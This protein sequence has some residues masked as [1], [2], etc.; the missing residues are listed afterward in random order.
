MNR[1]S[2]RATGCIRRCIQALALAATVSGCATTAADHPQDPFEGFNRAMFSFNDRLDQA[3]LKPAATVYA[4]VLPSFM[5]TA[6]GNF[7]GNIGDVWTAVN[8]LLQGKVENGLSD[9]M[10][11]AVN[12]T[13]GLVGL[14]DFGS[15]LGMPK[16]KEDFGQ[17]LGAWGM[18]S[19]PYVVLPFLGSTTL[20]DTAALPVDFRGDLWTYERPVRLRNAGSAVRVVDQRAAVL[21]ASNLIEDAA[22]DRYEFVRDAYLQRRANK[23]NDGNDPAP[24]REDK[25]NN[26]DSPT[27]KRDD[28][29]SRNQVPDE[30]GG[31]TAPE[32]LSELKLQSEVQLSGLGVEGAIDS[33]NAPGLSLPRLQKIVMSSYDIW[34]FEAAMSSG[35]RRGLMKEEQH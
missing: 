34:A 12:T 6:V 19:G 10:R 33:D 30:L 29:S 17:T 14:A 11:V 21:D 3:V 28:K 18:A 20:R 32:Q 9:V 16:H 2:Y 8:N 35:W 27:P 26:G 1:M 15:E 5:Q 4:E 22:L 7:F 31:S 25:S 23:I 13:F 24:K